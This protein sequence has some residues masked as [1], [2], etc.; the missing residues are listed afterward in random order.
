[1]RVRIRRFGWLRSAR[2]AWDSQGVEVRLGQCD[3]DEHPRV[4]PPPSGIGRHPRGGNLGHPP[5]PQRPIDGLPALP[6][7]EMDDT[8]SVTDPLVQGAEDRRG[9]RQLE[10]L[11]PADE[12]P[13]EFLDNPSDVP[14]T[15]PGR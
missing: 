2:K 15:V 13:A 11:F 6:L 5:S 4:L 1:M 10:V 12:I 7:L 9:V 3:V 14:P 8:E